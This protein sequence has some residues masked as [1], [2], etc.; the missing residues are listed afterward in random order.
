MTQNFIDINDFVVRGNFENSECTFLSIYKVASKESIIKLAQ[1]YN[2]R[3]GK[4]DNVLQHIMISRKRI[5]SCIS[6]VNI[7][8]Y[9]QSF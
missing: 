2:E 9:M 7:H 3:A 4:I 8:I 5:L 1:L 6:K